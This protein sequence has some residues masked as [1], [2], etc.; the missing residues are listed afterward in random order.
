MFTVSKWLNLHNLQAPVI[1]DVLTACYMGELQDRPSEVE[2][3]P[4]QQDGEL[5]LGTQQAC[6]EGY[7]A[8]ALTTG[9]PEHANI[10][11]ILQSIEFKEL[12]DAQD[13]QP[14]TIDRGV[15]LPPLVV[16]HWS[17][18][19]EDLMCLAH[20]AAHAL[21]IALSGKNTMPPIARETCAFIGELLL[22]RFTQKND[23]VLYQQLKQVWAEENAVYLLDNLDTL[24]D[25][26]LNPETPYHYYMNYPLARLAAVR[27]LGSEDIPLI[28]LF[29]SGASAMKHLPIAEMA[30]QTASLANFF[31]EFPEP[32]PNIPKLDFYRNLGAITLL[33]LEANNSQVRSKLQDYYSTLQA[34]LFEDTFVIWLSEDQRPMGCATWVEQSSDGASIVTRLTAPYGGHVR[35]QQLLHIKRKPANSNELREQD[36]P[37]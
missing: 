13:Y 29:S 23:P 27:L 4:V 15:A 10:A 5:C 34:H 1:R 33:D 19:P 20:E 16:M 21:Q 37:A 7:V 24:A 22:L 6:F 28:D 26:L 14:H 9:F 36:E 8:P 2:E 3:L 25:G 35:L 18:N 17:G 11:K 30:A 31:P 12:A 32:N